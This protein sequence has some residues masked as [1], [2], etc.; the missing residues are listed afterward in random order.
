MSTTSHEQ[1]FLDILHLLTVDQLKPRFKSCAAAGTAPSR[2]AELVKA[3]QV[4]LS[5]SGLELVWQA[6]S[7]LEQQAVRIS[8]YCCDGWFDER[9]FAAECG[10]LPTWFTQR[11]HYYRTPAEQYKLG[12][13]FYPAGRYQDGQ[14]IPDWLQERL[15]SL[16]TPPEVAELSS[17]E[18]PSP[19]P[20]NTQ[21]VEREQTAA[22][23]L[24]LM[25]VWLQE[26]KLKVSDKTGRPGKALLKKLSE[27]LVEH[28]AQDTYE[29]AQG[30]AHIKAF[31]WIMLLQAS[32]WVQC[33][34]GRLLLTSEG[35]GLLSMPAHQTLRTLWQD[36][37]D[38]SLLDEFSRID[39]IKGQT[40][41]GAKSLTSVP[42]RRHAIATALTESP[43]DGWVSYP[44]FSRFMLTA[45]HDFE[46]TDDVSSLYISDRHYGT[47]YEGEWEV[48]QGRYLRCVLLEYAATLGLIDVVLVPPEQSEPDFDFIWGGDCIECLSRYDGLL[49][50]RLNSLGAYCLG[51]AKDYESASHHQQTPLTM[52]KAGRLAFE[53]SPSDAELL[54]LEGYAVATSGHDWLL[55]QEKMLTLL[56]N[57]GS[58]TP[59]R[60]FISQRDTQPFLPQDS[61]RL[62]ANCEANAQAVT[63]IGP[64]LLL[65]CQD[66]QT[67]TEI[68][69]HPLTAGLC[70][71]AGDN[72]LLIEPRREPD[73]RHALH[74][75]GYGL[76]PY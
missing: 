65:H 50:I 67:A 3:M 28:Y 74:Q 53:Q 51:L 73:F 7:P 6:L 30:A 10:A 19:L 52:H 16:V 36:W 20:A 68:A 25:L 75:A 14:R 9:R 70:Q 71:A 57:G 13:F 38:S 62:L 37:L 40:G 48:L 35:L 2:K 55:S 18:L 27:E 42:D 56:E 11:F 5:G 64:V 17:D 69:I 47:F 61:E 46:I 43:I 58:L 4:W 44:N 49:Y 31:G 59:L 41:Y 34:A 23:E 45:G 8:L 63:P 39:I 1:A 60:D 29:Y 26:G 12:C 54:L 76:A 21:I 32:R 33:K 22:R 66:A 72:R 24:R 15:K